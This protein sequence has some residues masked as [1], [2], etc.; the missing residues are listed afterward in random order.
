MEKF[1]QYRNLAYRYLG[2]RNR[3]VKE[4]RDYLTRKNAS[5]EIIE[6]VIDSLLEKNF[7]NDKEFARAFVRSRSR[8]K[9]KGKTLLKIELGQKGIAQETIAE[10]LDELQEELPNE[11]EQ[12]KQLLAKRF[13][14]LSG[15]SREEIYRKAGGLLSRRGFSWDIVK[16]AIDEVLLEHK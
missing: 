6:K 11:L 13:S 7:L 2:F 5:E 3:S 4:M 1:E 12:A 16:K 15:K 10:V 8:L 9:P 14:Q